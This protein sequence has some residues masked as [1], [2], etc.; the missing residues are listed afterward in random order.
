[1]FFERFSNDFAEIKTKVSTPGSSQQ[2]QI[3]ENSRQK[4]AAGAKGGKT[5]KGYHAREIMQPV[6]SAGKRVTR[7]M[8]SNGRA[9][10]I[11]AYFD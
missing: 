11:R 8:R 7:V 3:I 1:M 2:M 6:P 4:R 5:C 10:G 9:T